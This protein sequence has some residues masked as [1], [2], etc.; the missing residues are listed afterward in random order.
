MPTKLEQWECNI[1]GRVYDHEAQAVI[2][3][4]KGFAESYPVGTIYGR[5][6]AKGETENII[7]AVASNQIDGHV[8]IGR[9]WAC[10]DIPG[11]PDSVG[12][13]VFGDRIILRQEA[14]TLHSL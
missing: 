7:Y 14:M 8:N 12:N 11:I 5:P 13:N 9:S 10:R 6:S 2:C 1:C 3:E 4:K